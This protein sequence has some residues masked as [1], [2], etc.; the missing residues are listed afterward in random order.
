MVLLFS[1]TGARH[2]LNHLPVISEAIGG[3]SNNNNNNKGSSAAFEGSG[4]VLF[5]FE[6]DPPT[7]TMQVKYTSVLYCC[8]PVFRASEQ[9]LFVVAGVCVCVSKKWRSCALLPSV[10]E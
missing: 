6:A 9:A 4:G 2:Y 8:S 3:P 1:A 5:Q 7:V 10:V